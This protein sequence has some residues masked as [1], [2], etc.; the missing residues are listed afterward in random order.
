MRKDIDPDY[1]WLLTHLEFTGAIEA[2]QVLAQ[3]LSA[4]LGDRIES[5]RLP[6]TIGVFGGW[7][8]GKTTF[9]AQL[10]KELSGTAQP[11]NVIYFNSWKYAGF[12]EIVPALI[13][14][15]IYYGIRG[16]GKQRERQAMQA[17]LSIGKAYSDK[18]GEWAEKKIG[19]NPVALAKDVVSLGIDQDKFT[20]RDNAALTHEYY[21]RVDKA[22]DDL[23]EALGTVT[24]GTRPDNP[25]VVLIDE[26]DRCD[27]D[28]AYT[29]IKQLR[30]C[31]ACGQ[32]RLLSSCA[33]IL[34]RLVSR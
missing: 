8:V 1:T 29:L 7:G 3:E 25:I 6:Y 18:F 14:K 26:L 22:Q 23:A 21:T 15:V 24:A 10:A 4:N 27:P 2:R 16:T 19:V 31:S 28:E 34:S 20:L 30:V 12:L 9:L 17:L 13:Y 32:C 11:L 5:G 33:Q